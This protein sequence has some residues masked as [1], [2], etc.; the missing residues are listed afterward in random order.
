M[1]VANRI[2]YDTFDIGADPE[3][4]SIG[5]SEV[6]R[7]RNLSGNIP[8][9]WSEARTQLRSVR[10]L[11]ESLLGGSRPVVLAYGRLLRLFERL[12]TRLEIELDHAHGRRC[13][14]ALVV[15]HIQLAV[16]NWLVCQLD[17]SET[18]YPPATGFLSRPQH[19]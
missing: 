11:L 17:V 10:G 2:R 15:Y 1:L 8:Q 12:E 19:A 9:G 5:P 13:G 14:P 16:R 7:L 18:E 6:S 3:S 4:G